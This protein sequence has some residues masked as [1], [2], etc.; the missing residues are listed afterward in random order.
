LLIVLPLPITLVEIARCA[1]M[2]LDVRRPIKVVEHK[3]HVCLLL[4]LQMVLY[5]FISVNFDFNVSVSL[6]GNCSWLV[7]HRIF[8]VMIR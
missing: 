5:R 4:P 7:K 1:S 6:S 8:R 3:I 2:S